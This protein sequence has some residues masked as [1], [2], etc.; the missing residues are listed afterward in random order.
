MEICEWVLRCLKWVISIFDLFVLLDDF[1]MFGCMGEYEICGVIGMGGM[2][3]VL[4]GYDNLLWCVV[5]IKI[6]VFYLVD[7]GLVWSWF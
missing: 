2:G 1:V 6:M 4:K 3:G 5:V 7:S